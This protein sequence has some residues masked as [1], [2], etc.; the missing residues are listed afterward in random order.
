MEFKCTRESEKCYGNREF[1]L[2]FDISSRLIKGGEI[3]L[4]LRSVLEMTCQYLGA[5]SSFLSVLNRDKNKINIEVA[6][7]LSDSQIA[8]GT[9]AVGEGIIGRVVEYKRP[10][11]IR[12]ISKSKLF[13]NRTQKNFAIDGE[14]SSFICVPVFDEMNVVG[15]LSITRLYNEKYNYDDDVRLLSIIGSMIIQAVKARQD[16]SEE[17]SKLKQTNEELRHSLGNWY[18]PKSIVGNSGK[19]NDVYKLIEMV[20]KTN[21]T[22][23]IR[24]ESGVGKELIADAIHYSSLRKDKAIIKVN[25]SALTE[26]LI[27]SELFGHEKGAFTGADALRKGRFE[28]ADGGTIFLDEIGDIPLPTQVKLLRVIQERQ[29]ERVGSSKTIPVDVRII[30]AT[31]RD[32]EK[33]IAEG[34]FREDLFYRINVFPLYLPSLRER[35]ND[36]PSLVD[37]FID[38]FNKQNGTDVKRITTSAIEMLMVYSW[39]GN[40]RELENVIERACILTPD[41][42]IHSYNLPPT[43]QTADSSQTISKG[44]LNASLEKIECQLIMEA[45]TTTKGNI[46]Q[47]AKNLNVTERILG[48]R[49]KKYRLDPVRFKV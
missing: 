40:V 16:Q 44:G 29:I 43:L 22:V 10:V 27:E 38:K 39:P 32:L 4:L 33:L 18:K 31:N 46:S 24:G 12:E 5:K 21:S 25:C 45:L 6:S 42:V 28:S 1:S 9:Y 26:S 2:L 11:I 20:S 14:E 3:N 7:G 30:A 36:I 48:I 34:K 47:A 41:E 37:H 35:R 17:I 15:T 8:R 13:L 23:M 49:V 19:M